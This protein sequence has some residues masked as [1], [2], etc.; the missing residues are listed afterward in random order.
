MLTL[1]VSASIAAAFTALFAFRYGASRQPAR[2][3]GYFLFFLAIEWIGEHFFL[4]P[5]ALG[6]EVGVVCLG[7]TAL[8]VAVTV[9]R[10]RLDPQP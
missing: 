8:L 4:P 2:V 9:L 1:F 5:G 7:I 3:A 10:D 6:V